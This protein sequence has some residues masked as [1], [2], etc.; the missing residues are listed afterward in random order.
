MFKLLKGIGNFFTFWV[1]I[2]RKYKKIRDNE[3]KRAISISLGVRSIIQSLICGAITILALWGLSF[4]VANF[5]SGFKEWG[6]PVLT[7]IGLAVTALAALSSFVQGVIGGLLYMIYQLKLNKRA[8][9]YVA[10]VIW[11]LVIAAIAVF[12]FLIF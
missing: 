9:G 11:I 1:K 8:V 5:A 10:L 12:A 4:C 6:L 7:I 2:E 3:D